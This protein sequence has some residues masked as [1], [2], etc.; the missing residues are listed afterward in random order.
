MEGGWKEMGGKRTRRRG[1][2][3]DWKM[4][5]GEEEIEGREAGGGVRGGE[6]R[7]DRK[8]GV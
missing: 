1:D 4:E 3:V 8:S 7:G 5:G 6:C 2:G